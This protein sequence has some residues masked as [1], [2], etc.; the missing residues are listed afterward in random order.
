MDF[1][2]KIGSDEE[3]FESNEIKIISDQKSLL[4]IWGTELDYS[5]GLNGKGLVW[6]NPQASRNCS[7]GS[8]F[9]V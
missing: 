8:S 1:S 7:C 6:N 5:S 9:S 4:Y 2:N 3:I